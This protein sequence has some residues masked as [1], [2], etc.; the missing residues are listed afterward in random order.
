MLRCVTNGINFIHLIQNETVK[1][2]INYVAFYKGGLLRNVEL[3]LKL[4]ILLTKS[5]VYLWNKRKLKTR[6]HK[7]RITYKVTVSHGWNQN[8]KLHVLLSFETFIILKR[9]IQVLYFHCNKPM[10]IVN[11]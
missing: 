10:L 3:L 5:F 6:L 1:R 11:H 2:T 8:E 4:Y 9:K 7:K